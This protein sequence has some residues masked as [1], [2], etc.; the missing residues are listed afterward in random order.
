MVVDSRFTSLRP[1]AVASTTV[2]RWSCGI[3]AARDEPVAL[4][5]REHAGEAGPEDEGLA[6]HAAGFDRA[7][8]AEH[9][10]H[11]PLLV[12]QRM[13]AQAGPRVRHDGFARL[14]QQA[15]QVAVDERRCSCGS[16]II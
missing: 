4:H 3:A 2:R 1:C 12:G 6:R 14:Q 8:L 13:L 11:A 10:Q 9:P 15:R 16:L 5:A 7:V